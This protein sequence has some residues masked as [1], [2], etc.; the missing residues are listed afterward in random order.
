MYDKRQRRR[1]AGVVV[2]LFPAAGRPLPLP[3]QQVLFAVM[4]FS[5]IKTK[6]PPVVGY[7]LAGRKI[8]LG[9]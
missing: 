6:G 9:C 2:V 7:P 3:V 4:K 5:K 1:V 8:E